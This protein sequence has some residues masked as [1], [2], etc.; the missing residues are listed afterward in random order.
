MWNVGPRSL[1]PCGSKDPAKK[2]HI[3]CGLQI[4]FGKKHILRPVTEAMKL[5]SQAR[6]WDWQWLREL[7]LILTNPH[8]RVRRWTASSLGQGCILR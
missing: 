3:P 8:T 5:G 4:A 6:E 7:Y 1:R 2:P